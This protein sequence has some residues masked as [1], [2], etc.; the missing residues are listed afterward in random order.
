MSACTLRSLEG[1]VAQR[2][3]ELTELYKLSQEIG[4]TLSFEGL[5]RLLLGHLRSAMRAELAA[6]GLYFAG[7]NFQ[8][9]ETGKPVAPL[10]MSALRAYWRAAL[11]VA[12]ED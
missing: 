1:T 6:G 9:I 4:Y 7:Y 12:G 3:S 5:M 11:A 8:F 2:T 10:A